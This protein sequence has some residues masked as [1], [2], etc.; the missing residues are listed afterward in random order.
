VR[1]HLQ[2]SAMFETQVRRRTERRTILAALIMIACLG[3][4]ALA[5][6]SL[7]TARVGAQARGDAGEVRRN[8]ALVP[9]VQSE[10]TRSE[11][12]VVR[13]PD[14]SSQFKSTAVFEEQGRS[15]ADVF[16]IVLAIA[17]VAL[18]VFMSA[19]VRS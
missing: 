12:V 5:Q 18:V 15:A 6:P 13:Q 10:P 3:S 7:S 14:Q 17:V 4:R 19:V 1:V 11:R 8:A 2:D 9:L 16:L